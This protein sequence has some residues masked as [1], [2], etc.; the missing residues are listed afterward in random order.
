MLYFGKKIIQLKK[1]HKQQILLKS[2]YAIFNQNAFS[3]P[4]FQP[5]FKTIEQTWQFKILTAPYFLLEKN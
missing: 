1:S 4:P 3:E 2:T 5:L